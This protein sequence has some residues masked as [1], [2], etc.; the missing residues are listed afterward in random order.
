MHVP[1]AYIRIDGCGEQYKGKMEKTPQD[2]GGQPL[3]T[4]RHHRLQ[5]RGNVALQKHARRN[6]S[7][8]ENMTRRGGLNTDMPIRIFYVHAPYMFLEERM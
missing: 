3:G 8:G 5:L 6:W 2:C 7:C 4:R 1:R